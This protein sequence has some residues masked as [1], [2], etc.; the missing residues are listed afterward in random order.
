VL[1]SSWFGRLL[2][3]LFK[4]SIIGAREHRRAFPLPQLAEA[5]P[6]PPQFLRRQPATFTDDIVEEEFDDLVPYFEVEIGRIVTPQPLQE[7]GCSRRRTGDLIEVVDV[8]H[9]LGE[10]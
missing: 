4:L 7:H 5:G 6:T 3:Y 10:P 1:S 9:F 2:I 8:D